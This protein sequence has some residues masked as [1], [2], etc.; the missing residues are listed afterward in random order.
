MD[1]A[2]WPD[3]KQAIRKMAE[4]A[5][6]VPAG[7]L[8]WTRLTRWREMIALV[9]QNRQY[10]GHIPAIR[11]VRVTC[12]GSAAPVQAFYMGAWIIDTLQRAAAQPELELIA[13]PDREDGKMQ[14]VELNGE[15]FQLSLSRLRDNLITSV[16][17]LSR[18]TRLRAAADHDL[19]N[20]ELD[21][22]GRDPVFERTLAAALQLASDSRQR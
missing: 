9:F 15:G 5:R 12:G 7:D 21:I 11:E 13:D 22:V 20:E 19:M 2:G 16:N 18:C 3:P 14:A 17:G 8:S 4:L 10:A 1:T 6:K